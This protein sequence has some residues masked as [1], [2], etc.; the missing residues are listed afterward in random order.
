MMKKAIV[1]LAEGFEE[2]EAVTC[3]DLLRRGGIEVVAAALDDIKVKGARGITLLSDTTLDKITSGFDAC[4]LPGGMP[5]TKR[6]AASEKVSLLIKKM[7]RERKIIAAICAAPALVL[8]PAGI[9]ENKTATCFPGMED[10]F[11]VGTAYKDAD[12][13]T[14]ENIIT[15]QGPA[16]AMAFAIKIVEKLAGK[17]TSEK[18]RLSILMDAVV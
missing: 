14:D 10:N 1:I 3:I 11:T 12:V 2:I 4:I 9:L 6:L 18:V 7:H 16:T 17:E 13:V 5:G 8:A 15:S